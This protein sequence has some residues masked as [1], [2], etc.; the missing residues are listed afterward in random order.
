MEPSSVAE[1]VAEVMGQLQVKIAEAMADLVEGAELITAPEKRQ[2]LRWALPASDIDTGYA[3]PTSPNEGFRLWAES[4]PPSLWCLLLEPHEGRE[5]TDVA[6][7]DTL[8]VRH[9][10]VWITPGERC[11]V[12]RS[13]PVVW[14][15]S[16]DEPRRRFL[17]LHEIARIEVAGQ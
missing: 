6:F 16:P 8:G 11:Y 9:P 12:D 15:L 3:P 13:K 1:Y 10:V 17:Y 5:L 4:E 2:L 14:Y 7:V